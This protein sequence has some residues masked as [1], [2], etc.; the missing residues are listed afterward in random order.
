[1]K[2]F[3]AF[4]RLIFVVEIISLNKEVVQ[5]RKSSVKIAFEGEIV[6]V[7]E[8]K[9]KKVTISVIFVYFNLYS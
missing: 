1:M 2:L 6:E 5:R 3:V 9:K 8:G 4:I 7:K